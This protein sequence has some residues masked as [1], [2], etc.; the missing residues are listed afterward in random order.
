ML[1]RSRTS[2][3]ESAS[4][5]S[6]TPSSSPIR[7]SAAPRP[8]RSTSGRRPRDSPQSLL[9]GRSTPS[10]RRHSSSDISTPHAGSRFSSGRPRRASAARSSRRPARHQCDS[11]RE[12][13]TRR[14][15]EGCLC[16]SRPPAAGARRRMPSDA[17]GAVPQA[18]GLLQPSSARPQGSPQRAVSERRRCPGGARGLRVV[19]RSA[20][21]QPARPKPRFGPRGAAS[22]RAGG[23]SEEGPPAR[24]VRAPAP[25]SPCAPEPPGSPFR[26]SLGGSVGV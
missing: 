20:S 4:G 5:S 2:S 17:I 7:A 14:R 3:R 21:F 23:R 1:F 10:R 25:S 8:Q 12:T 24:A 11:N 9:R 16:V 22:A 18:I 15:P 26:A 19:K 13:V 6:I